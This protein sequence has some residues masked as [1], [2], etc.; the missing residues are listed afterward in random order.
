MLHAA[1]PLA[2]HATLYLSDQDHYFVAARRF[3][4]MGISNHDLELYAQT[5][6]AALIAHGNVTARGFGKHVIAIIVPAASTKQ[7]LAIVIERTAAYARQGKLLGAYIA[8]NAHAQ[9]TANGFS[10][11]LQQVS[12]SHFALSGAHLHTAVINICGKVVDRSL[13]SQV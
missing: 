1:P 4:R 13:T 9:F 7:T 5:P 6:A 3:L 2:G 10:C 12:H 11:L 8:S